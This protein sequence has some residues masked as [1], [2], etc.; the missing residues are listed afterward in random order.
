MEIGTYR[1]DN[2]LII[3]NFIGGQFVKSESYIES[4]DPST[5][6]IWA[7]LPD[8]NEV[9]VHNAVIAAQNAFSE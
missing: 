9:D 8:S 2:P 7:K 3:E 6:E 4:F 5:G 1:S